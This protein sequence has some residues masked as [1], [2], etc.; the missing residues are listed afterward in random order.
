LT[1]VVRQLVRR[2]LQERD[3]ATWLEVN[4]EKRLGNGGF[5]EEALG[6]RAAHHRAVPTE[7]EDK[8]GGPCRQHTLTRVASPVGVERSEE[9]DVLGQRRP[10][11][12]PQPAHSHPALD[13]T[14]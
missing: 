14:L 11:H 1:S 4:A 13:A 2:P 12:V 3:R 5:D 8:L 9:L 10:R 6:V 7:H